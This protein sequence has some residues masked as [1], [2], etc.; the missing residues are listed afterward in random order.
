MDRVSSSL[1]IIL[2][3]VL[4]T[5]WLVTVLSLVILLSVAVSGRAEIFSNPIIWGSLLFILASGFA[6]IY[7]LLWRFYRIDMDNKSVYISNYFKTFKYS[8][9]DVKSISGISTFPDRIFHMEL[10]SKGSFGKHIYFLASQKLWQDF[11][12]KHPQQLRE[13]LPL[14]PLKGTS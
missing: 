7:F 2:R 8:F 6:F 14:I 9:T 12:E 10:K 11:V 13:I 5:V 4:P 1:T 3:I